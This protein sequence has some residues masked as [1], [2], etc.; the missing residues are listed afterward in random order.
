[1]ECPLCGSK[2]IQYR[3]KNQK[4]LITKYKCLYCNQIFEIPEDTSSANALG[5]QLKQ[6]KEDKERGSKNENSN[7][8]RFTSII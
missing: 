3:S 1:M 5:N 2:R 8:R 6:L 7:H 4:T